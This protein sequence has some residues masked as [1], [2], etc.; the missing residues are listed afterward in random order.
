MTPAGKGG[1]VWFPCGH[2]EAI[3]WP[4]PSRV[5]SLFL[6]GGFVVFHM[7]I[8][9]F[10]R[11]VSWSPCVHFEAFLLSQMSCVVLLFLLCGL[12]VFY[13]WF[14]WF[15]CVVSVCVWFSLDIA[16]GVFVFFDC[17]SV[18]M[19]IFLRF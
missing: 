10:P 3:C 14:R 19:Q 13:V 2:G 8:I 9:C 12:V 7:W 4:K 15:P 1:H 16:F 18:R 5:V 11:V 6:P 17:L